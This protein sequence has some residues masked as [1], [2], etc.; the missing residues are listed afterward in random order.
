ME[1]ETNESSK[2]YIDGKTFQHQLDELA[3]TIAFKVQREGAGHLPQPIFVTAD[4][5]YLLR[6]AQQ[7]YNFFCFINADERRQKDV[8][9]R[10]AYSA[11]TLPLVRTMID[12][13]YNITAILNDPG[14]KGYQFRESGVKQILEALDSDQQKYGG[15]PKWDVWIANRRK[16][17]EL[18]MRTTGLT[19]PE[20][21]VAKLWPTL[22]G[23][24]R[25]KKNTPLT[26]HQQFLK[27]LT[28]G[29]WQE[30]SGISHATF[31]GLLPI[32][33]FLAPK[34]LPHEVRPIIEDQVEVLIANH[35]SR[36]AAI[37]L[38]TLTELQAYFKFD[39]ARI[40]ERLHQVWNAL[41]PVPEIKELY[42]ERYAQLMREKGINP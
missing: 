37:L 26:A 39:G 23:Y 41:V 33:N 34:D 3:T 40:N 2:R 28:Y 27:R 24:L 20:V 5:Y 14:P 25:T 32:G 16:Q 22:G 30:Y 7:T 36:V 18:E 38:C 42:D 17:L 11:V 6:Q 1:I 8:D 31:Q 13:L 10:I 4:I 29:F 12:C 19:E 9:Y 35:I 15:D 21:R